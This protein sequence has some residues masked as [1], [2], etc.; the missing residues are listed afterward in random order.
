[1]RDFRVVASGISERG[2]DEVVD[3]DVDAGEGEE[4]DEEACLN[5][6]CTG[7]EALPLLIALALLLNAILDMVK[8]IEVD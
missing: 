1:V 5:A 7:K 4:L 6:C 8:V 3:V 2:L